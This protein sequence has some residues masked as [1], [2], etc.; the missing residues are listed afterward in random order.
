MSGKVR[1]N[2][3]CKALYKHLIKFK[4]YGF[5]HFRGVLARFEDKINIFFV[6]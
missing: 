2:A 6:Y 5:F 3:T 4:P 1:G